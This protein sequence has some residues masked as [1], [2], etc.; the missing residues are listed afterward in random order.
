MAL[1]RLGSPRRVVDLGFKG[2]FVGVV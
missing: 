2:F 1:V